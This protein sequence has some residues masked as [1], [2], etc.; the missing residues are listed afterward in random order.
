VH[1]LKFL[2]NIKIFKEF[3]LLL[4]LVLIT[5]APLSAGILRVDIPHDLPIPGARTLEDEMILMPI[6]TP[7]STDTLHPVFGEGRHGEVYYQ[8]IL[9]NDPCAPRG[10]ANMKYI[11]QDTQI[12]ATGNSFLIRPSKSPLEQSFG[13]LGARTSLNMPFM[14]FSH[15]SSSFENNEKINALNAEFQGGFWLNDTTRCDVSLLKINGKST[16]L[17]YLKILEDGIVNQ[18]GVNIKLLSSHKLLVEVSHMDI[19]SQYAAYTSSGQN[20]TIETSYLVSKHE[21]FGLRVFNEQTKDYMR[22]IP[23]LFWKNQNL[24][25]CAGFNENEIYPE[26]TAHI[27]HSLNAHQKISLEGIVKKYNI[28]FGELNLQKETQDISILKPETLFGLRS[29]LTHDIY[30]IE[31]GADYLTSSIVYLHENPKGKYI[32]S[33]NW[34]KPFLKLGVLFNKLHVQYKYTPSSF[35]THV[36]QMINIPIHHWSGKLTFL[37]SSFQWTSNLDILSNI[38]RYN[39]ASFHGY[40]ARFGMNFGYKCD[41]GIKP[42][43]QYNLIKTD[44]PEKNFGYQAFWIGIEILKQ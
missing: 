21:S 19:Q 31:I 44:V 32:N 23:Y 41:I 40:E 4:L 17:N 12:L 36:A 22:T 8:G 26:I 5:C 42:F 34:G 20:D 25:I 6:I 27:E 3:M 11:N 16:Y 24:K 9:L 39:D 7:T 18:K 30:N 37:T 29:G 15:T 38:K 1:D 33:P 14:S 10:M 13:N 35:V 43:I 28:S 2:P